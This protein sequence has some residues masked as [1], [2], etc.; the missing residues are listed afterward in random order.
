MLLAIAE[1][2]AQDIAFWECSA[3]ARSLSCE[4]QSGWPDLRSHYALSVLG[5]P[6]WLSAEASPWTEWLK[7]NA[8]LTRYITGRPSTLVPRDVIA[9]TR[10]G[11]TEKMATKLMDQSS[12]QGLKDEADIVLDGLQQRL[13]ISDLTEL[14]K[15]RKDAETV[16]SAKAVDTTPLAR[17]SLEG[18]L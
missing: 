12:F 7:P 16:A 14:F 6:F 4:S 15:R 1:T 9:L 18:L 3:L 5:E 2:R 11:L 17:T 10:A 13:K 8:S